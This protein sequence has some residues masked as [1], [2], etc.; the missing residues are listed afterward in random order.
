[1]SGAARGPNAVEV[2]LGSA[3]EWCI[4]RWV[5][6]T[7]RAVRAADAPWLEGPVGG[8]RIGADFY[9]GYARAEGLEMSSGDAG[10]LE[11][12]FA[13]EGGAF[14]PGLVREEVRWFYERTAR[15]GLDVWS[16]WRGPLKPFAQT[17]IYLVSRDIEQLNLP[18][19]P[20]A[21]S[22]GMSSALIR[23]TNPATGE[24]PYAGW[25]R[26][27]GATDEVIYAGFYTTC[28]PPNHPGRCVK[29]VFPLP[30]GSAT[31]ILRPENR[32]DGSFALVSSGKRF[33]D[34]GYYRLHR[35]DE[36]TLRVKYVPIKEDIHV[37]VDGKGILRT[38]HTFAFG[39]LR[40]LALHY[41]IVR[42]HSRDLS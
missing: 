13:L 30:G 2:A 21:T 25:L 35:T 6:T 17:L 41:K 5:S 1:M 18:M 34:P 15:Y 27:S 37:F 36:D 40:F 29:V 31:V 11:D 19:S 39:K 26:R 33:G 16:E 38:H 20:L 23:F 32:P 24:S 7:G 8:R 12:F 14:D 28:K 3:L 42:D 22:A 10:L 4:Q 9:A